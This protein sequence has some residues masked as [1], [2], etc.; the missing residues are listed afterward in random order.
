MNRRLSSGRAASSRNVAGWDGLRAFETRNVA[1]TGIRGK[2]QRK[3]TL[4]SLVLT[5][6]ELKEINSALGKIKV[7]GDRYPAELEKSTGL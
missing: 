3:S 2:T 5:A 6:A 1:Q 7:V 4:P